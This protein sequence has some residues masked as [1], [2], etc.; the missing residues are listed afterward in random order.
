VAPR[1]H[2]RRHRRTG[3]P[4]K[5]AETPGVSPACA[6]THGRHGVTDEQLQELRTS[7]VDDLVDGVCLDAPKETT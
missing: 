1:L 5:T 2:E 6:C 7:V 3:L 4:V